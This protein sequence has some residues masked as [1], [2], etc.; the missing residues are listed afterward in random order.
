MIFKNIYLVGINDDTKETLSLALR[1]GIKVH[2]VINDFTVNSDF[3]GV[4]IVSS[5]EINL[6]YVVVNCSSSISPIATQNYFESLGAEVI[7]FTDFFKQLAEV[8]PK[9]FKSFSRYKNQLSVFESSLFDDQSRDEFRKVV[10]YRSTGNLLVMKDF[11]VR[12]SE[13]YLDMAKIINPMSLLDVGGFDGDTSELFLNNL[14]SLG[15]VDFFEPNIQ[16]LS[17]AKRRL[18]EFTCV[19]Y[20]NHGLGDNNC[21]TKMSGSGSSSIIDK[22]GDFSISVKKLDDITILPA[23]LIKIDIE[24]SE[25]SCLE[26][27]SNYINEGNP[28]IAVAT[29]HKEDDFLK[30]PKFFKDKIAHNYRIYFRHYTQGWSES[31]FFFIP[32]N[33]AVK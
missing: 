31:I 7:Y 27:A 22:N 8:L 29:Y 12:T 26:G 23:D 17:N 11:K 16:N 3:E 1:H 32:E 19:E 21:Q 14:P 18:R 28:C 15:R 5:L 6:E 20:H 30:I 4:P 2:G 9:Q 33:R 24:G 25:L 13:Q 10:E